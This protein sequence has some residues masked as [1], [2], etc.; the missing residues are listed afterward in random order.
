MPSAIAI[1]SVTQLQASGV[2]GVLDENDEAVS[3]IAVLG[4]L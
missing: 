1:S 4:A 3:L 2:K